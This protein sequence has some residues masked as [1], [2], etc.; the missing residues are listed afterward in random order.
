MITDGE[1]IAK[2]MATREEAL[3]TLEKD[4][5]P[6]YGFTI[7]Q[8]REEY[9]NAFGE[10]S[11]A[12][13]GSLTIL[14]EGRELEGF[15]SVS[16]G[17]LN[18]YEAVFQADSNRVSNEMVSIS[19]EFTAEGEKQQTRVMQDRWIED[20][21]P[22][23]LQEIIGQ[24]AGQIQ[25][26]FSEPVMGAGAADNYRLQKGA[27]CWIPA[28][29]S[30]GSDQMS[31]VLTFA[32]ELPAG[33]YELSCVNIKDCSM[34]Q[35]LLEGTA[36]VQM[37]GLPPKEEEAS[38]GVQAY[39]AAGI[40]LLI[41]LAAAVLLFARKRQK[42]QKEVVIVDGKAVLPPEL[43]VRQR[44]SMERRKLEEKELFF[45][46]AGQKEEIR[47]LLQK[48]MI[49][50]RA[51]SCELIFDD[52]A[53]SRQHFAL[54]IRDG[55]ILIQNLSQG[56]FTTVN[57]LRLGAEAHPLYPGDEISAGQLKLTVRW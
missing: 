34:E 19:L 54:E 32:E 42:D 57:G 44:V 53:L 9:L 47:V 46:V 40:L 18:S 52:P 33:S 39:A 24:N 27:D 26:L 22:P 1:D 37:E 12:T 50:G 23:V 28:Y 10:F 17:L 11:R 8:A 5:I 16:D 48:S 31:A 6:V 45:H 14:E 49:V 13:G 55:A 4:G 56:G 7:S 51:S 43:E 29:A 30:V 25:V 38:G 36:S 3:Q 2:G 21:E 35:N 15:R 20:T 41:V